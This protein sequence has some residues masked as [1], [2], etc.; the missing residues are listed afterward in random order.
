MEVDHEGHLEEVISNG[1]FTGH[2]Q[3]LSGIDFDQYGSMYVS[4]LTAGKIWRIRPDY[5]MNVIA[6]FLVSPIS[7]K[8]DRSKH[9]IMV[10]YLYANG[11]E[12]NGLERPVNADGPKKKKRS[13]SDYGLGWLEGDKSK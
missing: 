11:A 12:M 3:H 6:E 10:S 9:L 1:F 5:K 13:L 8:I 4:D 2:F 7:V